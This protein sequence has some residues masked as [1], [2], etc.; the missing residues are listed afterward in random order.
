MFYLLVNLVEG[1]AL[2]Q[3]LILILLSELHMDKKKIALERAANCGFR[4]Y[5]ANQIITKSN[6]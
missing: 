4:Q 1:D 6:V 3:N 5:D 2:Y